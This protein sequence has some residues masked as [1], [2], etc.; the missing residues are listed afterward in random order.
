MACYR[1]LYELNLNLAP[2]V[3]QGGSQGAAFQE[4]LEV[5]DR[6]LLLFRQQLSLHLWTP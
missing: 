5:W 1:L 3:G 6:V 4:G 2:S